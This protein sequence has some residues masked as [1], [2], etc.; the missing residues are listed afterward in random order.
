MTRERFNAAMKEIADVIG[1]ARFDSALEAKLNEAFPPDGDRFAALEEAVG[2]A[3]DDG[4]VFDG[5]NRGLRYGRPVK[6]SADMHNLSVDIVKYRDLKGPYHGHPNGEV[7]LILPTDGP[8]EFD[9]RG[10]G[11]CVYEAGS[12]H[13]PVIDKGEA[14]VVYL[15]PAG[16][17]DFKATPP[18]KAVGAA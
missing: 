16:A 6:P 11:W 13:Y 17:I 15:L 8:A 9:G 1:D 7:C 12:G 10:R 14:I 2:E 4:W 3:V 18:D 5:E